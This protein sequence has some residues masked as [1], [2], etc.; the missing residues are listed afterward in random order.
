ML[1][2]AKYPAIWERTGYPQVPV[3]AA[4]VGNV[5][6]NALELILRRLHAAGCESL[7]DASA[8]AVLKELGGYTRV[9]ES[10]IEEQIGAFDGNPRAAQGLSKLRVALVKAVPEMRQRLQAVLSRM[11][12]QPAE[13]AIGGRDQ[14]DRRAAALGVGSHPEVEL[15]ADAIR[16]VGRADLV[17]LDEGGCALTDYKTGAPNEHHAEQLKTYAL[18]WSLDRDVN[19]DG[20][21]V[22]G[23]VLSY[24]AEDEVVT[25]PTE[26]ELA[27]KLVDL[28]DRVQQAEAELGQR[29]PPA[30][31]REDLCRYCPVRHMCDE[32]WESEPLQEPQMTP[33]QAEG[34][35]D[36]EGDV[37]AR[38]GPRSWRLTLGSDHQDAL[39]RT[40]D[41][42]PGFSAGDRIRVLAVFYGREAESETVTA[43]MTRASETYVLRNTG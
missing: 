4:I 20:I 11:T 7:R 43:T 36:L 5:V 3:I 26:D 42:T 30:Y 21:P 34:L 38:N 41:E 31:P 28:K 9:V 1:A 33:S 40:N 23:L 15:R 22:R 39:L 16:F 24:P 35:G 25:P 8:I 6:H 32:Y 19:P 10:M 2:R 13:S 29:P 17:T 12:I 37:R 14:A 27:S 18:L